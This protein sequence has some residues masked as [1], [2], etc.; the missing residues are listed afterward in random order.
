MKTGSST[1]QAHDQVSAVVAFY[2]YFYQSVGDTHDMGQRCP[3]FE[4]DLPCV[5]LHLKPFLIQKLDLFLGH[6]LEHID[7]PVETL[8]VL[9]LKEFR[10]R[11][12]LI[13]DQNYVKIRTR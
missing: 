1:N 3:L 4:N 2:V 12:S 7:H 6:N 9:Y 8:A 5:E 10:H 13:T 11:G